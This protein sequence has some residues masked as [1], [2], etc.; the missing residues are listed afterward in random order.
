MSVER[1]CTN[2]GCPGGDA[3]TNKYRTLGQPCVMEYVAADLPE[4]LRWQ[5]EG[6]PPR[7]WNAHGTIVY[8]S[9]ADYCD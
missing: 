9:F 8:R 2:A 1:Y 7:R 4:H 3:C 6:N 5:G